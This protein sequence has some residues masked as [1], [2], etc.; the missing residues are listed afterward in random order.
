MKRGKN[1]LSYF[2]VEIYRKPRL[3]NQWHFTEDQDTSQ[4]HFI[5]VHHQTNMKLII[6]PIL[7]FYGSFRLSSCLQ[8]QNPYQ[9]INEMVRMAG[10][11]RKQRAFTRNFTYKWFNISL[12]VA[13]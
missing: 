3:I 6:R 9:R 4:S 2:S 7:S 8:C 12:T 10:L 5:T 11:V 13:R 1:S